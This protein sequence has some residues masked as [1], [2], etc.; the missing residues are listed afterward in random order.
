[1]KRLTLPI[2]FLSLSGAL[3]AQDSPVTPGLENYYN[4]DGSINMDAIVP[5]EDCDPAVLESLRQANL[6]AIEEEVSIRKLDAFD[7]VVDLDCLEGILDFNLDVFGSISIPNIM[8]QVKR[9]VCKQIDNKIL[10]PLKNNVAVG[11]QVPGVKFQGVNV[12]LPNANFGFS[13]GL[14]QTP[15]ASPNVNLGDRPL[16]QQ[17]QEDTQSQKPS[18]FWDTLFE[19]KG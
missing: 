4:S 17:G 18:N 12:S 10:A 13:T 19:K 8:D 1:M 2:L 3:F 5:T 9:G 14:S 6:N 7:A 15:Q 16:E 11:L